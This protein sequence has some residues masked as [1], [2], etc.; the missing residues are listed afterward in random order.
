MLNYMGDQL[1][2]RG[3]NHG[4]IVGLGGPSAV[5]QMV[6]GLTI[7]AINGPGEQFWGDQL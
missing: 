6:R 1:W 3:T 5:P 4:T 7:A 2:Q